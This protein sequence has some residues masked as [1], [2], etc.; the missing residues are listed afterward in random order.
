VSSEIDVLVIGA[1]VVGLAAAAQLADIG[2][3]VVIA[4]RHPRAGLETSTHN[5]GVIHAGLYY[6]PNSLKATLCVAGAD[7]LLRYCHDHRVPA[8]R[9]GKLI[10]A[11][12]PEDVD[13][14]ETIRAR[15]TANGVAGLEIVD[16]RFIR[17]HEP[18]I[19]AVAA[20]WS[21]ATG[22]VDASALVR[23]L[24]REAQQ[25]GAIFLGHAAVV[26]GEP[27]TGEYE[28]RLER[29]TLNARTVVNAAGLYADE[30]S[31]SLGGGAFT[32]YPCRGEYA[33]LKPSRRH[34][35]NGLVY[36]LPHPSG[37]GLGVHLTRATDGS[38]L[39]GPSIRYQ[40][41]RHD[42]ENDRLPLDAFVD[43]AR[44]MLPELTIDDVTYGG[45]GIRAKLHP[46]EERFA[47]FLIQRDP[48][49][50][51]LIQAAGIDSPGLT[52]CLAIA[53]MIKDLASE[54]LD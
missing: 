21:P 33:A 51:R 3:S 11:T 27:R 49:Q 41:S 28:V 40:Q 7:L 35:V 47:D 44:P 10:V 31:A 23:A 1:G 30:V 34:L 22:R 38:V 14:L 8:D 46:P 16:R 13:A 42:Y 4:E 26:G 43:A 20:L 17:E 52:S 25:Y 15:G 24:Q 53:R 32:I 2:Y 39:L 18:R 29:E 50:P 37:H 45:S 6:P 5:S 36:P 12:S 19:E 54:I 48:L 9:C